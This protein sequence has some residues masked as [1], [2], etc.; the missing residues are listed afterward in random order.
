MSLIPCYNALTF[1]LMLILTV[2][3]GELKQ[4]NLPHPH[5]SREGAFVL[6]MCFWGKN[7]FD[8]TE[9]TKSRQARVKS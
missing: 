6:T 7:T 8:L 4:I 9:A 5:L 3:I 2:N 1:S